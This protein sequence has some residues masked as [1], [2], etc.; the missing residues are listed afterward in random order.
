[1]INTFNTCSRGVNPSI[2]N[3]I[4]GGYNLR[5]DGLSHPLLLK[6]GAAVGTRYVGQ[7]RL[8]SLRDDEDGWTPER[9]LM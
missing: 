9:G 8:D 6:L 5:G 7:Q 1:V 2:L 4:G 3:N